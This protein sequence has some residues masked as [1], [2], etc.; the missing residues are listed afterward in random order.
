MCLRTIFL[1]PVLLFATLVCGCG[2]SIGAGNTGGG[3]PTVVTFTITGVTPTAVATKIGSGSFTPATLSSGTLTLT[4]PTGET[5]FAV[6]YS[7]TALLEPSGS[8]PSEEMEQDVFEATTL[9][10]NSFSGACLGGL[11]PSPPA[12]TAQLTGTV[13][14][15]SIAGVSS[16]TVSAGNASAGDVNFGAPFTN[17]SSFGFAA[18]EGTDRVLVLAYDDVYSPP[19]PAG[20][21][22]LAAARS[23]D[24]QAVP[25]TLNGGNTVT[26]GA[27]DKTTSVAITYGN[28]PSGFAI[29]FSS[30][31]FSTGPTG[32]E[33]TIIA[34]PATTQYPSLPQ[35]ATEAGDYYS[36]YMDAYSGNSGMS[37]TKTFTSTVPVALTFPPKWSYAGPTPAAQPTFQVAYQGFSGAVGVS[38]VTYWSWLSSGVG[39]FASVTATAT[40]L[41]G[42]TSISMPDLSGLT[43]SIPPPVSGTSVD[44]SAGITQTTYASQPS[45]PANATMTTVGNSGTYQVP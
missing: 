9:D 38:N 32:E 16:F 14:A 25:G 36:I 7:C 10:G 27:A 2:G 20:S 4:I 13:D 39:Y 15:S 21:T 28:L 30:A 22:F 31:S 23:F 11:V 29:D 26:L 3:A 33:K 6:A 45:S 42:A 1:S 17:S 18:P 12:A 19:A 41:N 35:G 8:G 44:W 24:S 40:Y 37:I 43:V 34:A 5:N